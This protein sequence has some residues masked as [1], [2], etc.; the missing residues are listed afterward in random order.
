MSFFLSVEHIDPSGTGTPCTE[1]VSVSPEELGAIRADVFRW[2]D[3][4]DIGTR[5]NDLRANQ[6]IVTDDSNGVLFSAYRA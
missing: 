2:M 6:V 4:S 5:L 1:P 3:G